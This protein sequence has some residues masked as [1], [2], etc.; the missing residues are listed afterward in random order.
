[1]IYYILSIW[2]LDVALQGTVCNSKIS[3]LSFRKVSNHPVSIFDE[4]FSGHFNSNL[5][6][7]TPYCALTRVA[8]EESSI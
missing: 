2:S 1:M 6:E 3:N 4:T 7:V 8:S 5:D